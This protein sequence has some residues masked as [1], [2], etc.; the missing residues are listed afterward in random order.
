M[1]SQV[2]LLAS[3]VLR[4]RQ[5]CACPAGEH[6]Q[7]AQRMTVESVH[8]ALDEVR[9]YLLA[10]GGLRMSAVKLMCKPRGPGYLLCDTYGWA[11]APCSSPS[12]L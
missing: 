12:K 2:F 6:E 7:A 1:V 5:W 11:H 9:H 10:A 3:V 8:A 4:Q